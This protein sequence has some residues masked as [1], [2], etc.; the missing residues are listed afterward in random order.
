[1]K[2]EDEKICKEYCRMYK[3]CIKDGTDYLSE[4]CKNISSMSNKAMAID[5][6]C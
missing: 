2:P 6:L 5:L 4:R 1:M 3:Y